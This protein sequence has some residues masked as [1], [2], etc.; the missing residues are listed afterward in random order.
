MRLPILVFPDEAVVPP[1]CYHNW[2][3]Y[4]RD[5]IRLCRIKVPEFERRVVVSHRLAVA[6]HVEGEH[7][8]E[9]H[10]QGKPRENLRTFL[11]KTYGE[12]YGKE[13]RK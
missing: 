1:L 11:R 6:V 13:L 8:E 9:V 2:A 3:T 4:N 5:W 10:F 12:I 7:V